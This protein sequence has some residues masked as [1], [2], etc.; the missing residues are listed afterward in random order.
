MM[1]LVGVSGKIGSGKDYL[2]NGLKT[3]LD[4][5][6]YSYKH[7]SFGFYLKNEL[8][9]IILILREHPESSD[10]Q[11]AVQ[12]STQMKFS[13]EDAKYLVD[14][15]REHVTTSPTVTAWSRTLP[16]RSG[17]QYHGTEIRRKQKP[18]YWTDQ[19]L[20]D[21]QRYT[22]TDYIFVSDARFY[23]EMDAVV[24]NNG[25]AIRLDVSP[26][27]LAERREK[28]DSIV[29]TPEQLNHVSETELDDY[30]RFHIR[31]P[32]YYDMDEQYDLM[33]NFF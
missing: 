22:T 12:L 33:R 11:L 4:V 13:S 6:G 15:L 28:R 1:R 9:T 32:D 19:F 21:A 2:T 26:E 24:D 31:L 8:D 5:N 29:Y 20:E 25:Y 18:S 27:V 7:M 14:L 17:L 3:R 23:N 30:P 10:Q 16:V